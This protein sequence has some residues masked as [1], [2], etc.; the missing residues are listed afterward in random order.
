MWDIM[1]SG[2]ASRWSSLCLWRRF[3]EL[4]GFDID[5]LE[6]YTVATR[7][8]STGT[9]RIILHPKLPINLATPDGAKLF[10]YRGD[11]THDTSALVNR[12]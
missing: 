12:D 1:K 11:V 6:P 2:K 3:R 7:A 5:A 4:T 9:S 8:A 10:G